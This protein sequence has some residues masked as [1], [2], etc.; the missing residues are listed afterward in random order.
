MTHRHAITA[1]TY[2]VLGWFV[3]LFGAVLALV[4]A[5]RSPDNQP[6]AGAARSM[7]KAQLVLLAL[8]FLGGLLFVAFIAR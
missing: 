4:Y 6:L 3:P 2:A 5:S 8:G 7:A 1:F